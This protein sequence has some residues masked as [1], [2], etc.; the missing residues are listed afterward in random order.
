MS[1]KKVKKSKSI[2][3]I[4]KELQKVTHQFRKNKGKSKCIISRIMTTTSLIV[5]N[6]CGA[7]ALR[8][9]CAG[10]FINTKPVNMETI[11]EA[12]FIFRDTY[13]NP[14]GDE[15]QE[16]RCWQKIREILDDNAQRGIAQEGRRKECV[17]NFE[18]HLCE[19]VSVAIQFNMDK[20]KMGPFFCQSE[21]SSAYD[22]GTRCLVK[23][24]KTKSTT[25]SE[26]RSESWSYFFAKIFVVFMIFTG[27]ALTSCIH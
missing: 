24:A 20:Y 10:I 15:V 4:R 12:L 13:P 1:D 14:T 26:I 27:I 9:P 8:N 17:K 3:E 22:K 19:M 23:Y 5:L 18:K 2:L 7:E 11:H 21:Y 25:T 6:F 16:L